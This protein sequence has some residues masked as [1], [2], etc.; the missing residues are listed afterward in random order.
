MTDRMTGLLL[1]HGFLLPCDA[2]LRLTLHHPKRRQA[3]MSVRE[4]RATVADPGVVR[5][6]DEGITAHMSERYRQHDFV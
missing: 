6:L 5:A 2:R 4:H 3:V 1:E